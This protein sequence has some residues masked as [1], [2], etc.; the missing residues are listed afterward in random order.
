MI[1]FLIFLPIQKGRAEFDPCKFLKSKACSRF[2]S[3]SSSSSGGRSIPTKKDTFN[4]NPANLPIKKG[5]GISTKMYRNKYSFGITTGFKRA[6]AAL[7]PKTGDGTFFGQIAFEKE[8]DFKERIRTREKFDSRKIAVMVATRLIGQ[9][10]G[11]KTSFF[12]LNLGIIAKRHKD[13][14]QIRPGVG[15]LAQLGPFNFGAASYKDDNY[16]GDKTNND[17]FTGHNFNAGFSFL[18]YATDYSM[19]KK[20]NSIETFVWSHSLIV[21]DIIL[22]YAERTEY[23][24]RLRYH[25]KEDSFTSVR[26][27]EDKFY[28]IQYRPWKHLAVGWLKNYHLMR[29][30]TW[31]LSLHW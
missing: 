28:G 4:F 15:L 29:G 30:N 31:L 10:K 7:S 12:N 1:L 9:S 5:L 2:F 16:S 24:D 8:E 20:P 26:R 21:W 17:Q 19:A 22:T 6:G 3:N 25:F 18:F 14:K 27:K 23:S 13:V 11:R